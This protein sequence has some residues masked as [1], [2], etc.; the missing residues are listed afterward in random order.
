MGRET[1]I[2]KHLKILKFNVIVRKK[3]GKWVMYSFVPHKE[4]FIS[5]LFIALKA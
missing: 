5:L 2:S 3:I 4:K 1:N